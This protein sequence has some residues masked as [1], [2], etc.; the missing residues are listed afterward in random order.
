MTI[1]SRYLA[2]AGRPSRMESQQVFDEFA[3]ADGTV[4]QGWSTVL[5]GLD[6]F[7]DTDLLKA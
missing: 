6:E 7:A 2:A 3:T 1:L 5:A 4:R